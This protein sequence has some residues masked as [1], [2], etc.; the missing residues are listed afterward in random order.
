MKKK[1][2]KTAKTGKRFTD[3]RS[4][5]TKIRENI[6]RIQEKRLFF[7][8]ARKEK[9]PDNDLEEIKR[10]TKKAQDD[11][12]SID[13]KVNKGKTGEKVRQ[14]LKDK[15]YDLN[16][17]GPQLPEAQ[18]VD[19]GKI[20]SYLGGS[21]KAVGYAALDYSNSN[22]QRVEALFKKDETISYEKAED[23]IRNKKL[24]DI[25]GHGI[26]YTEL[27]E[28]TFLAW[29]NFNGALNILKYEIIFT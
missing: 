20:W 28:P 25:A 26:S 19:Y 12:D 17:Y 3:L 1:S 22:D 6:K 18:P 10:S 7:L 2:D 21:A 9:E 8:K 5:E 4:I 23:I 29:K 11:S 13:D 16:K 15:A 27:M 24:A 14:R